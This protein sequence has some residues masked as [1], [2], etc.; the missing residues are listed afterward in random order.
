MSDYQYHL[1]VATEKILN[2]K[3]FSSSVP[4]VSEIKESKN[5][6]LQFLLQKMDLGK[7]VLKNRIVATPPCDAT[8]L[9]KDGKIDKKAF[10]TYIEEA[11]E[12]V[13]LLLSSP[14]KL[15][16]VS[17]AKNESLVRLSELDDL[18][19]LMILY[20]E[21]GKSV[22]AEN[23]SFFLN[24]GV[25][26]PSGEIEESTFSVSKMNNRKKIFLYNLRM[27]KVATMAKEKFIDG[28]ILTGHERFFLGLSKIKPMKSLNIRKAVNSISVLK[29]NLQNDAMIFYNID[30]FA[31]FEE[32]SLSC[33]TRKITSKYKKFQSFLKYLKDLVEV[34][35]DGFNIDFSRYT[36]T[37]LPSFSSSMPYAS[38]YDI[39]GVV[40]EYFT[41]AK[42]QTLSGHD[43]VLLSSGRT[44]NIEA[45]E[46]AIQSGKCDL[47]LFGKN[48]NSFFNFMNSVAHESFISADSVLEGQTLPKKKKIAI[49]GSGPSSV[50]TAILAAKRG[51]DVVVFEKN[52]KI[53]GSFFMSKSSELNHVIE[54]YRDYLEAELKSASS[55]Y[56]LKIS[57]NTKASAGM[58]KKIGFDAIIVESEIKQNVPSFSGIYKSN[59]VFALDL[60]K[61]LSIAKSS[62]NILIIGGGDLGCEVAYV[63]AQNPDVNVRVLE[64]NPFFMMNKPSGHRGFFIKKLKELGVDLMNCARLDRIENGFVSVS[65][66]I[67]NPPDPYLSWM[68]ILPNDINSDLVN[69]LNFSRVETISIEADLV[70][71][72]T[73]DDM[74]S[75]FYKECKELFAAPEI[76]SVSDPVLSS[77]YYGASSQAFSMGL[78]I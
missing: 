74:D 11:R 48:E 70:V 15:A 51:H 20:N 47:V 7:M 9:T 16:T 17:Y 59:V 77:R 2:N 68:P 33:C 29:K 56:S 21:A 49:I 69:N 30:L 57:L 71:L 36:E 22:R 44:E 5:R 73:S 37:F 25:F 67:D 62:K 35:V 28:V 6:D 58:L 23:S 55:A 66:T 46:T 52:A 27:E 34:G 12:G 40:K 18:Q 39:V 14:V 3:K 24:V 31:V 53:G 50:Q 26:E 72:A 78:N 10:Y 61:D 13:G 45:A 65:R 8:L 64:Q 63:L 43:V 60:L 75:S 38:F 1:K 32:F 41:D 42:I 54:N 76:Y 4:F 19:R